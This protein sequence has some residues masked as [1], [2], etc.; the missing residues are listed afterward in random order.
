M[1][2]LDDIHFRMTRSGFVRAVARARFA[3][4]SRMSE[5]ATRHVPTA[6]VCWHT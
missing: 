4:V 3:A 6:R 2:D 5:A 1:S